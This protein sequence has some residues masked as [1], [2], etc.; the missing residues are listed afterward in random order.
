MHASKRVF[1]LVC[2]FFALFA[3]VVPTAHA[4]SNQS[5]FCH[6]TDG[7][8]TTCPDGHQEWSDITPV[9]FP[10]S[11]SYLYADQGAF[12]NPGGPPDT[13]FLMYDECSRTAPLGPNDYF[14]VN[15]ANVDDDAGS[16]ALV[17]YSIHIFTDGTII[18][19][20]NGQV[21]S[22]GGQTRVPE[23]EGQRGRASFGT[24]PSCPF[25]H[26]IAEFQIPLQ[27]AGTLTANFDT[28]YSPDPLFWGSSVPPPPPPLPPCPSAGSGSPVTLPQV[29]A[30]VKLALKD[31]RVIYGS[32]PLTFTSNGGGVASQCSVTSN[33]GTLPVLF[34][35]TELGFDFGP[36]IQV[37][38]SQAVASVNIFDQGGIDTSPIPQCNFSFGSGANN[39]FINAAPGGSARVAQWFTPGFDITGPLG[40]HTNTGPLTFYVNLDALNPP[41]GDFNSMLQSI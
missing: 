37:A 33:L 41:T 29:N 6:S 32:I 10:Q 11:N 40:V 8:F 36:P 1:L 20:E 24:S 9:F 35:D 27:S 2:L 23:I 25:N 17:H 14:L 38:T 7:S 13:F 16:P 12:L 19:L 18:F 15:F 22:V 26:L 5:A 4:A 31:Y 30:P 28:T 3:F 39:C 34:Q 21:Q